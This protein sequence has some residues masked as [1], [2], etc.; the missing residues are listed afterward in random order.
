MSDQ[1]VERRKPSFVARARALNILLQCS[2][3]VFN[4]A[5]ADG[6]AKAVGFAAWNTLRNAMA[7]V[8]E[9]R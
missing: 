3:E 8:Q 7:H 2:N 5:L 9:A 6:A 1:L 4:E